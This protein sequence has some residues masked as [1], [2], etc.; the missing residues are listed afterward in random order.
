MRN[1]LSEVLNNIGNLFVNALQVYPGFNASKALWSHRRSNFA[2]WHQSDRNWCWMVQKTAW[3]RFTRSSIIQWDYQWE[4]CV[5]KWRL[6]SGIIHLFL[7]VKLIE[8]L[9]LTFLLVSLVPTEHQ[10][11]L[12]QCLKAFL[13]APMYYKYFVVF[14]FYHQESALYLPCTANKS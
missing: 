14:L 2:W 3:R 13:R 10:N 6:K 1:N 8:S 11:F 12:P 9:F 4:Y 7:H 5:W